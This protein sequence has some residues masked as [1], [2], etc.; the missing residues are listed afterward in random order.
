MKINE[1]EDP[2]I[3]EETQNLYNDQRKYLNSKQRRETQTLSKP[4]EEGN[5]NQDKSDDKNLKKE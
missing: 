2:D 3:L 1:K 4:L 5:I